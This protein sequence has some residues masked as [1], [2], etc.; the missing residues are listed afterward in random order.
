ML[1]PLGLLAQKSAVEYVNPMIGT[2][3]HGHTYPG[4]TTPFGM[5]QVSPEN[6]KRGWDWCSGYH[7]SSEKLVGFS[8]LHLSGTGCADLGDILLMPG[9]GITKGKAGNYYSTFKHS[10]EQASAG[11][12]SVFLEE[13]KVKVELTSTNRVGVQ[14]YYFPNTDKADVIINLGYGNDDRSLETFIQVEGNNRVSGYR[15]SKGWADN[16]KVF[17]V[18]EFSEAFTSN[19]LRHGGKAKG[20]NG[21]AVFRFN[22]TDGV[23]LEVKVGVSCVSIEGAERNL[24]AESAGKSFDQILEESRAMWQKELGVISVTSLTEADKTTFYTALYHTFLAPTLYGDV[25]GKYRGPDG[26]V[27]QGN[28]TNYCTFSLWDTFRAEH[29]LLTIVQPK[30]VPDLINSL[31]N[32]Q[33]QGGLLPVWTLQ[34]CETNCMIGYHSV[35]VI[36]DAYLKGF[37]GFDILQ[38]YEAAKKSALSGKRGLKFLDSGNSSDY[39]PCDRE[40]ESVSKALEYAFDDWCIAQMA[41][42]LGK[43]EDEQF[44]TNRAGLYKNYWDSGTGFMRGKT[45]LGT[46]VWPFN[47]MHATNLQHEYTEGNAWQYS[48]FVPHDVEG[49]VK[50]MGGKERFVN[51]LDSLFTLKLELGPG[52]PP[53]VSG[54]IGLYAHGNEPSHHISYLYAAVGYPSKTHEMVR[55]IMRT[56]YNDSNSGLCGNEDC[57]QMSAWYVFSSLG[58]Y[59]LNPSDGKYYLG[60]PLVKE[61][62]LNLE[63]G[64][65]FTIKA[66]NQS[67]ENRYV[68]SVTLNGIP[69]ALPYIT[70]EE[71]LNGGVLE[72]SMTNRPE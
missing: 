24:K 48:W 26:Q 6:G 70:H 63:N 58:F 56:L 10:T 66:Q 53:D 15:Y 57:G 40:G 31:L 17:F 69:V 18:A 54:L 39:I 67:E 46:W 21:V 23:P 27:H 5:V 37:T 22:A 16:Q 43:K 12:Y 13:S 9:V 7:Y 28:F 19:S 33:N 72:F 50:L 42:K 38:S 59:P 41:S 49:L 2:A 68:K 55:K 14:R 52:A 45:S 32:F 35:P 65:T 4:A 44:F 11:Y 51:R 60:S 1:L 64:K 20:K 8:N 30:R 29:P 34:G 3:D 71:L 62:A 47:P 36:V 61:A 25:D